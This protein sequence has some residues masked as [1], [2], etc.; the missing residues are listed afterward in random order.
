[1]KVFG[2]FHWHWTNYNTNI[3]S[4]TLKWKIEKNQDNES[5]KLFPLIIQS[6]FSWNGNNYTKS[7]KTNI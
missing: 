5:R 6:I 1:M 7:F 3:Q 4:H 2:V